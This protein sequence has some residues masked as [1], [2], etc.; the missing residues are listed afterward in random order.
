MM[1]ASMSSTKRASIAAIPRHRMRTSQP[2]LH[3]ISQM[4][5]WA[6]DAN[7][8]PDRRPGATRHGARGGRD[9][10]SAVVQSLVNL[11]DWGIGAQAAVSA[12]RST[13]RVQ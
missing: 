8:R 11:L 3:S 5:P 10:I 1:G 13:A 7:A 12:P 2:Q 9:I 4:R 6:P